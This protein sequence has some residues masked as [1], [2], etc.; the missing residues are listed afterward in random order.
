MIHLRQAVSLRHTRK[1]Q[2]HPADVVN[3]DVGIA[4]PGTEIVFQVPRSALER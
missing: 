3:Q 4:N 2:A 1:L